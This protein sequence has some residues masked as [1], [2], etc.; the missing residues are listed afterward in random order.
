MKKNE[1]TRGLLAATLL[2][3]GPMAEAESQYPATNFEPVILFQ[4]AGYIAQHN[5]PIAVKAPV[6]PSQVESRA[7]PSQPAVSTPAKAVVE[8][9]KPAP[10]PA[11]ASGSA[12]DNFPVVLILLGLVGFAFWSSRRG[13]AKPQPIQYAPP[14]APAKGP[15]ADSGVTRYLNKLEAAAAARVCSGVARYL[16][17]QEVAA[18]LAAAKAADAKAAA[19]KRAAD[20]GVSRYLKRLGTVEVKATLETGV[21]QYLKNLGA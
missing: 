9:A 13:G 12:A 8:E 3:A 16:K 17:R 20:T 1:L 10:A 6:A 4:D 19:E 21:A 2:L 14:A 7:A 5:Q 18:I 15:G 11:Q